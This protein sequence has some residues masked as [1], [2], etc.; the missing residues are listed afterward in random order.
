MKKW[1][2]WEN[3]S[4]EQSQ[5]GQGLIYKVK[6]LTGDYD[7]L[8]ALKEEKNIN[9]KNRFQRE[10]EA[11]QKLRLHENIIRIVDKGLFSDNNKSYYVM[12]LADCTLEEYLA[13]IAGEYTKIFDVF[14]QIC[15]GLSHIHKNGIM[16]RDLKPQNILIK[17][18][19]I[20]ISDFGLCL[21]VDNLRMTIT[22][23]AVGP[24]CYMAPELEDGR[25]LD[26]T[27]AADIYSL[28]KVLY[29][30]LSDGKIFTREKYRDKIF[31]LA[32]LKKDDRYK[33]FD[34]FFDKCMAVDP[35]VRIQTVKAA[36]NEFRNTKAEFISHP[37]TTVQ[38]KIKDNCIV[39]IPATSAEKLLFTPDELTEIAKMVL[40]ENI[41]VDTSF[42]IYMSDK[43]TSRGLDEFIA[44]Y[45][46]KRDSLSQAEKINIARN[47][48]LCNQD[49]RLYF[50]TSHGDRTIKDELEFLAF[51]SN[52][53]AT[54]NAIAL[55]SFM[56]LRRNVSFLKEMLLK[57]DELNNEAK[58][59]LLH[60]CV[61]TQFDGKFDFF[62]NLL[63]KETEAPPQ[64]KMLILTGFLT[65]AQ[66]DNLDKF[67]EML[68]SE[69]CPVEMDIVAQALVLATVGNDNLLEQFDKDRI[70]NEV[71]KRFLNKMLVLKKNDSER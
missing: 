26:V 67:Y 42:I 18:H 61:E 60:E 4:S 33:C 2:K 37:L 52:D 9:R 58:G 47:V 20:K 12:E 11:V 30:M 16:H 3:T 23:E 17:D 32:I 40:R 57:L 6:C 1:D 7:G 24:R 39:Q 66:E 44:L 43:V 41:D 65:S 27:F 55:H 34:K 62:V 70:T 45:K 10:I 8:Y 35:R 68:N 56:H 50:F 38:I 49:K 48:I 28:S 14:E 15:E 54:L 64:I 71:F 53:K 13:Y 31:N 21:F 46:L 5:G 51:E 63:L 22:S 19:V 25:N 29:Y 59:K 69:S 36:L